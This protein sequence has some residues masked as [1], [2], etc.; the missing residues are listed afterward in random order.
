[1]LRLVS[2]KSNYKK[3]YILFSDG[4]YYYLKYRG[5][6]IH[7]TLSFYNMYNYVLQNQ[8]DIRNIYLSSM[9]LND[10]FNNFAC[11][12]DKIKGGGFI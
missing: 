8:I 4:F 5:K 2:F 7:C 1:M 11:F 12:D 10:F 9:S 3:K 6:I